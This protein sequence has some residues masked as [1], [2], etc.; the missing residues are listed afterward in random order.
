MFAL[1]DEGFARQQRLFFIR[2]LTRL[3]FALWSFLN[4]GLILRCLI[5]LRFRGFSL[6][7][8]WGQLRQLKRS[9]HLLGDFWHFGVEEFL[10]AWVLVLLADVLVEVII[11]LIVHAHSI[12]VGLGELGGVEG[13]GTQVAVDGD[14]RV[15]GFG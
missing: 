10:E 9:V 8:F 4:F 14:P 5:G 3:S 13:V 7:G 15:S 11:F 6:E 1:V 2:R 12:R